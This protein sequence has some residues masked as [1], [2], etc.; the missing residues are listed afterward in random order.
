MR[1]FPKLSA[2][3]KFVYCFPKYLSLSR[4]IG[5]RQRGQLLGYTKGLR[6]NRG[7]IGIKQFPAAVF[8]ADIALKD[9]CLW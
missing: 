2:R 9:N 1:H 3:L 6:K 5:E 4:M 8:I 7:F